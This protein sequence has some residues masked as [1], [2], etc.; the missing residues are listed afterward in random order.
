MNT[1]I[2]LD[3]E[4][5]F[6]K[7]GTVDKSIIEPTQQLV[8]I[9]NK[10]NAKAVFF[11]DIGYLIKSQ[12]LEH[13]HPELKISS[14][15]VIKQIKDLVANGHDIQLHIHSHWEDAKYEN[16]EWT[17]PM[18]HYRLHS[19]TDEECLELV[20]RYKRYLEEISGVEVQGFRAGGWCIQ[21]FN[22]LKKT[23]LEADIKFDSTVFKGGK[24]IHGAHYYNFKNIP[25]LTEW[26]FLDD[27][28][29]E[30][31]DGLFTEIPI[32]SYR[33]SPFFFW[34]LIFFKKFG[35]LKHKQIGD[36]FAVNNGILQKLRLLFSGSYTVVSIDGYKASYLKKAFLKHI[37]R[38]KTGNFVVIGHPKA[39]STYS[40]S[41][42]DTFLH[43]QEQQIKIKTFRN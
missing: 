8:R 6:G 43:E 11:V 9:L 27:P 19:F 28:C 37:R 3:Y 23:F 29:I 42:L 1:Y 16:G 25:N 15:K 13:I 10:Y 36:G 40:L 33:V 5:F 32:S 7:S 24:N 35:G 2:T 39:F 20:K 31:K 30:D 12:Q 4:L 38:Y 17:F 41:K 34:R 22:K 14:S 21:P 18:K 26:K